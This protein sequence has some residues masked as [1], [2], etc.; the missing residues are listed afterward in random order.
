[1]HIKRKRE[2]AENLMSIRDN[3]VPKILLKRGSTVTEVSVLA[4][5]IEKLSKLHRHTR[6][7]RYL[8]H[9]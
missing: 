8:A 4:K 2:M 3:A 7:D 1:M 6:K 5:D 9:N